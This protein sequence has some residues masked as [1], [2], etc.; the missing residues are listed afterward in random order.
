MTAAS[1]HEGNPRA[2]QMAH[3]ISGLGNHAP[4]RSGAY[5]HIYSLLG[6]TIIVVGVVDQFV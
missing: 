4:F 5:A 3:N 1:R 2:W 6:Q